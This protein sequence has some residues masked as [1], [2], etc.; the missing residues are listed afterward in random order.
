MTDTVVVLCTCPDHTSAKT[1][2][3]AALSTGLAGCVNILGG[4]SSLYHWQGELCEDS[5]W[6]LLIKAPQR[7]FQ[8]LCDCIVSHHPYEVP[9]IIALPIVAAHSPYLAWL[10]EVTKT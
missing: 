7:H 9:E 10:N 4:V 1:V 8:A 5:E 6:Q 2:A 3:E